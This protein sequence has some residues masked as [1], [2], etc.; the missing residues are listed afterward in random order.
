MRADAASS[1]RASTTVRAR[2][3]VLGELLNASAA[4]VRTGR[5]RMNLEA[6]SRSDSL[7]TS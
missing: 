4:C 3:T 5:F 7:F 1:A 6:L 2:V